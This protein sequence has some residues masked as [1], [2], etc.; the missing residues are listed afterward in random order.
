MKDRQIVLMEGII[1]IYGDFIQIVN[2][3]GIVNYIE[4]VDTHN[5]E[6]I[7]GKQVKLILEITNETIC[8]K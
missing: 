2:E 8:D 4:E 5:M 7:E 6:K 1:T 3:Q